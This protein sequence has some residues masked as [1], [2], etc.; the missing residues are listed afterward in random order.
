MPQR[1]RTGRLLLLVAFLGCAAALGFLMIKKYDERS[2]APTPPAAIQTEAP[3][4]RVVV[5]FFSAP[6]G[7]GLV[8][9]SREI[10][11]CADQVDCIR[12][13]VTELVRGPLGELEPTLPQ[14]VVNGI[15]VA[16]GI[17]TIDLGEGFAT[18][19]PGGSSSE[20]AAAYSIVNSIAVNIPGITGVKFLIDGRVTATLKGNLDLRN[21]LSPDF[22]LEKIPAGVTTG[23]VS[24]AKELRK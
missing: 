6:D 18:G 3:A 5:L 12:A 22:S 13:I 1:R 15:S 8:R 14:T 10:D 7:S 21:P 4:F 9:E 20:M 23:G 2:Q 24:P 11:A 19:L 17:A 16:N